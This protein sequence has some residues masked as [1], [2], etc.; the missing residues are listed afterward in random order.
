MFGKLAAHMQWRADLLMAGRFGDL[1]QEYLFPP[2][3]YHGERQ[4]V[5]PDAEALAFARL[6]TQQHAM[7]V[8][9]LAVNV[10]AVDLPRQGRFRV[11]PRYSNL[12]TQGHLLSTADSVI[13]CKDTAEGVKSEMVE[14]GNC[15]LPEIWGEAEALQ[16]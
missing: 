10:T 2:V 1:A 12:D 4:M 14:W 15:S 8:V 5:L 11:W 16:A 3:M 7:G 6:R 9:R 13:Y